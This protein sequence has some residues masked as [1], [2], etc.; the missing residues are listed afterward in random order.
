MATLVQYL[1]HCNSK[2][3]VK[4][5]VCNVYKKPSI[6]SN[7]HCPIR[8]KK[9]VIVKLVKIFTIIHIYCI[10]ESLAGVWWVYPFEA[11]LVWQ[12]N[13]SAKWILIVTLI[14]WMVLVWRLVDASPNLPNVLPA[15]PFPIR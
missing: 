8:Q 2:C 10:G 12:M 9:T 4:F 14:I 5:V 3:L 1:V 7:R 15:K 11:F 6:V 13:R